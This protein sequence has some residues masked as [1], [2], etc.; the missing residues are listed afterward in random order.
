MKV[1]FDLKSR[2]AKKLADFYSRVF[3]LFVED[4]SCLKSIY[5]LCTDAYGYGVRIVQSDETTSNVSITFFMSNSEEK[6]E[7]LR[8]MGVKLYHAEHKNSFFS[9]E[10]PQGNNLTINHINN[11]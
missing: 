11:W 2:N 9:F 4:K 3:D 1:Q 10:D 7:L 6:K 5:Y 8:D